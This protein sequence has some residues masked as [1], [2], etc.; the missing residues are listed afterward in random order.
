MGSPPDGRP[1]FLIKLA[2]PARRGFLFFRCRWQEP[3]E[4]SA[5]CSTVPSRNCGPLTWG[6]HIGCQG[7]W[8]LLAAGAPPFAQGRGFSLAD[9]FRDTPS[10]SRP[11]ET[12][13]VRLLRSSGAWSVEP[14]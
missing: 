6:R 2:P 12:R 3:R 14:A 8:P 7:G 11:R 9:H 4:Q 1:A 13:D 10:R 5:V